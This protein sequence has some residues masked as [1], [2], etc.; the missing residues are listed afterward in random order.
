MNRR[1]ITAV[2]VGLALIVAVPLG[3]SVLYSVDERE[4]AVLLQFGQPVASRFSY[5][6]ATSV[7]GN[8]MRK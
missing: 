5:P 8:S 2:L 1:L 4:L 7:A 3:E 6:L